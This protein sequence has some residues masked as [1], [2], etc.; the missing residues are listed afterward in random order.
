MTLI[1]KV[2]TWIYIEVK[3]SAQGEDACSAITTGL[4]SQMRGFPEGDVVEV[5][6]DH[7][8]T[9]SDEEARERGLVE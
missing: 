6:V 3:D 7:F 4:E 8:E 2:Q 9:V 1:I 5:D